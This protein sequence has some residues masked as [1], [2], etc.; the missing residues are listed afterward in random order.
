MD[1]ADVTPTNAAIAFMERPLP[2]DLRSFALKDVTDLLSAGAYRKVSLNVE[3]EGFKVVA[4]NK[5][6]LTSA[7]GTLRRI[8]RN[9]KKL[10]ARRTALL[11]RE[12]LTKS[13]ISPQASVK[14]PGSPSS[15]DDA[16]PEP[17][18]RRLGQDETDESG[19]AG[20]AHGGALDN[21]E[22][23]AIAGVEGSAVGDGE[24]GKDVVESP[25]DGA[26][27]AAQDDA[28]PDDS[29]AG[30]ATVAASVGAQHND[31]AIPSG[32]IVTATGAQG[33]AHEDAVIPSSS[34]VTAAGAQGGP[35]RDDAV[36]PSSSVVTAAGAQ[37]GPARDDA[38][39]PSSSVVTAAG[40]QGGALHDAAIP[41][42]SVVTA[43]GAQGG[44]REGAAALGAQSVAT[45]TSGSA[46]TP[47]GAQVT[48]AAG[49][50]V[51]HAEGDGPKDEFAGLIPMPSEDDETSSSDEGSDDEKDDAD[52]DELYPEWGGVQKHLPDK[53]EQLTPEKQ[54]Q[55]R[56]AASEAYTRWKL[57]REPIP[58][59]V[60]TWCRRAPQLL[61]ALTSHCYELAAS[62]LIIQNGRTMCSWHTYHDH[63]G[64]P[65]YDEAA[66]NT[67]DH[68]TG[69]HF[70]PIKDALRHPSYLDRGYKENESGVRIPVK[71]GK[72]VK[73]LPVNPNWTKE[74]VLEFFPL[75]EIVGGS[76][77]HG[78]HCGCLL[79]EVLMDFY[80]WK[81]TKLM[82]ESVP[83]REE[84]WGSGGKLRPSH[85]RERLLLFTVV[86]TW[87]NGTTENLFH[88][89]EN[90][91]RNTEEI[92][93]V[94]HLAYQLKLHGHLLRKYAHV[95]AADEAA[96]P[97]LG[98]GPILDKEFWE[99]LWAIGRSRRRVNVHGPKVALKRK[100]NPRRK[101]GLEAL[102]MGKMLRDRRLK[103][104]KQIFAHKR[105]LKSVSK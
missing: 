62:T 66:Q 12:G 81:V 43:A 55:L 103:D 3:I 47:A 7:Q 80:F 39:S 104:R 99:R 28:L 29:T 8:E 89:D 44:A 76:Q 23:S 26:V 14:R 60:R 73:V 4:G 72:K 93:T 84:H 46:V 101:R 51:Q 9:A 15:F 86:N 20:G 25:E 63:S 21:V 10:V 40:A 30:T 98:D 97:G 70:P 54:Q 13:D 18:Q 94:R 56:K 75:R 48:A 102:S 35:A 58:N 61:P 34:V 105:A 33:G 31:T 5:G 6:A 79:D 41:S 100:P 22:G 52:W 19:I 83:G 42:S 88:Y 95:L 64:N 49:A 85:P 87:Y 82:S 38:V 90:G 78:L 57:Y 96:R 2:D 91:M 50:P 32:P 16:Q 77:V 53:W 67:D 1:P 27:A 59:W 24:K 37:G 65:L 74:R 71:K 45:I 17:K 11:R 69:I 36:S 68:V 92:Q